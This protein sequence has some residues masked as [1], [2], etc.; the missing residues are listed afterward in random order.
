[1]FT[2]RLGTWGTGECPDG[3][4]LPD[5]R[6]WSIDPHAHCGALDRLA[7]HHINTQIITENSQQPPDS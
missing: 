3:R 1:M 4:T 6:L 7:H 5:Q 2:P